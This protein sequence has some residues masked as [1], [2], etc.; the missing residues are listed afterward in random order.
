M[1]FIDKIKRKIASIYA[2]W[3]SSAAEN[4]EEPELIMK[5]ERNN[6]TSSDFIDYDGMGNQGRFPSIRKKK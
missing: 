2:G 4:Q 6:I 5:R 3:L 1:L